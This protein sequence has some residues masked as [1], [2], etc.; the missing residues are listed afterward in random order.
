M[1]SNYSFNSTIAYF[2]NYT[3]GLE[4]F[5]VHYYYYYVHPVFSWI[6]VLMNILCSIVFAQGDL[7]ASG[8]FFQYS[9]ANSVGAAIGMAIFSLFCVTRCGPLCP[10]FSY[11]YWTQI[12]ELY[13][14]LFIDNSLYFGSSLVQIAI[15][16]Q[17]YLSVTQR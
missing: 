17:L 2:S 14:V 7:L 5:K 15:S 13:G 9:L 1:S 6:A 12:Y 16:F 8:P 11:A 4:D 10:S 3:G